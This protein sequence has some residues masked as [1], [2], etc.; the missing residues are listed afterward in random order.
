MPHFLNILKRVLSTEIVVRKQVMDLLIIS[1]GAIAVY[2]IS[3]AYDILEMIVHFSQ[4]HENWEVDE[5]MTVTIFL[6]LAMGVYIYRRLRESLEM[7][8]Q[9]EVKTLELEKALEEIRE[10]RQ[11]LP[12]CAGCRKVRDEE[13]MW[14]PIEEFFHIHKQTDFSHGMCPDCMREWYPDVEREMKKR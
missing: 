11:I 1:V 12:I 7:R 2:L 10:L 14:Y 9:L 3:R 6:S 13:G 4:S 5:L 8:G